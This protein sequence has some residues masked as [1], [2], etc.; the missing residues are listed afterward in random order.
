MKQFFRQQLELYKTHLL[1]GEEEVVLT[2]MYF[3]PESKSIKASWN[4]LS[5][6]EKMSGDF[7]GQSVKM[8]PH[9]RNVS[10]IEFNPFNDDAL[11]LFQKIIP[12]AKWET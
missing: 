5:E 9:F 7:Q 10:G 1:L 4:K 6:I 12:F 3:D 11:K 8:V 2:F